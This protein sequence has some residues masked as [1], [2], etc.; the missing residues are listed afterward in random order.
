MLRQ[1]TSMRG[2]KLRA[3]DGEIGRVDHFLFDDAQWT[4]RYM[5][6]NTGNWLLK[7]LVLISPISIRGV[8]WDDER[9]DVDLTRKQIEDSPDIDANQPVSRQMEARHAAYYNYTP[10]WHG[11]MLWGGSGLP[12]AVNRLG[13]YE[14]PQPAAPDRQRELEAAVQREGDIHLRSTRAVEDYDIEARDGTIGHVSDFVIDD[15]TWTMRYFI[16]ATRNWLPGKHVLIAPTWISDIDWHRLRVSVDLTR[17]EVKA[18]P[19]FDPAR[20]NREYERQLHDHYRRQN[21]WE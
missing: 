9:V 12:M 19:T 4:I 11:G 1:G 10:Y 2:L 5:V 8:D 6:V 17:D 3:N 15:D 14:I 20:L 7:E 21:Y 13:T 16:V 18:A